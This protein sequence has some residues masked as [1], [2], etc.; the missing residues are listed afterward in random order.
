MGCG[1]SQRESRK[2]IISAYFAEIMV[3]IHRMFFRG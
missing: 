3:V 2:E 1:E